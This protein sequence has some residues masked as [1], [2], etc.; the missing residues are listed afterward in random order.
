M[1]KVYRYLSLFALLILVLAGCTPISSVH[2]IQTV[3]PGALPQDTQPSL[4]IHEAHVE[5]VEIQTILSGPVQINA[6]VRGNLT[7]SCEQLG[8]SIVS[9][10]SNAFKVN[11][12]AVSPRDRGCLQVNTPFEQSITLDTADLNPGDYTVTA[13]GVSTVF[14]LPATSSQF[15]ADFSLVVFSPDQSI[16]VVDA[17][18][19]LSSAYSPSFN[20]LLPLGGSTADSAYVLDASN[21]PRIIAIDQ[22]GSHILNFI[23]NPTSYGL[24]IWPGNPTSD[25][26][27][28]WATQ[29]AG[30]DLTSSIQI[31]APDGSQRE[32]LLTEDSSST[33]LQL[34]AQF[35]ST[36]GQWL[37]FSKEPMGIGGYIL[38]GGASSLFRIN[39]ETREVVDVLGMDPLNGTA[40]CLD[41]FSNDYRFIAEHCSQNFITVRELSSNDTSMFPPPPEITTGSQMVGSARFSPDGSYLAYA[42]AKGNPDD[43]QGWIV[44]SSSA[45]SDSRIILTS[46][47]GSY[48]T[49]AG[50]LDD[51]TLL[52]QLTNL[53]DCT[54]YCKSELWTIGRDGSNPYKVADGS[55]LTLSSSVLN[56]DPIPEATVAP[57]KGECAESAQYISDDGLDGISYLPNTPF[58]K[59]WIVKNTGNCT[60]YSDYL[61]YQISGELMTQQPGYYFLKQDQT[62]LPG[63]T[64]EISV[65]MTS[66]VEN[67][68]YRS[69]WGLKD[70]NGQPISIQGGADGNSFYVDIRVDDGSGD[71]GQVTATNVDIE[72]EQGS[73]EACTSKSTYFVHASITTNGAMSVSYEIGSSAGQISAGYFQDA[74]GQYSY[75][76]GT[77]IFDKA[78]TKDINL[79]FVGPYPYPEDITIFLRV[80]GEE[81]S[82]VK[83]ECP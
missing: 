14:T 42:V 63:Q 53:Q 12:M 48:Y 4:S 22:N 81:W 49:I 50:W 52:V 37:Y 26:R 55:F 6:I 67:G 25:A 10:A 83:L 68:S 78:D 30:S 31:S 47:E 58:T 80:S 39:V 73:G 44:V 59:T 2:G 57:S 62:V 66:P 51:Q 46:Q 75:A 74:N 33:H 11:L 77:L 16:Q 38:F 45:V 28:A 21:Q 5:S 65:G 24:A 79:R 27:L 76:T 70:K 20:G 17:R 64:V 41:S 40:A 18:I 23:K 29:S 8:D 71:L 15:A 13:N 1:K 9:Y 3:P 60:W 19:P 7:E 72:P 36:D 56:L 43:E 61:V 69:Y 35:W 32:T 54:P 34:M 82:K